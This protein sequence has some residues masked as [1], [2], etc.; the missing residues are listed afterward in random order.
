MIPTLLC[1]VVVGVFGVRRTPVAGHVDGLSLDASSAVAFRRAVRREVARFAEEQ[2]DTAHFGLGVPRDKLQAMGKL[3]RAFWQL[4]GTLDPADLRGL[5]AQPEEARGWTMRTDCA[6][7]RDHEYAGPATQRSSL[8][9]VAWPSL[10]G[11]IVGCGARVLVVGCGVAS[12]VAEGA[13]GGE[14]CADS[15]R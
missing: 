6:G 15:R 5:R 2:R 4:A 13:A 12:P 7:K 10:L 3:S 11:G 1:L 8:L 9:V 14:P